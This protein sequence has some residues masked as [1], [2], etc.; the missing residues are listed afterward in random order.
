[1]GDFFKSIGASPLRI[2]APD[3]YSSLDRG[4]IEMVPFG[5]F[6]VNFWKLYEVVD[7]HVIPAGGDALSWVCC[8]YII[9]KE[10]FNRFPP[11]VQKIIKDNARWASTEL[12][13][14][15]EKNR[16][17]S[18]NMFRE[19]GHNVIYLTREET[20]LWRK[21]AAPVHEQWIN[22][23]EAKGLPGKRLY[24]EAKRLIKEYE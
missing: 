4:L 23:M 6:M 5:A 21:A 11:E 10:R 14:S 16:I 2:D 12:T 24:T 8:S 18:E 20:E 7:V 15:E 3:W 9:N 13:E 19:I 22:E 1:M 17:K